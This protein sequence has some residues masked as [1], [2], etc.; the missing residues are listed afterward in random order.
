MTRLVIGSRG[1]ELA[2]TQSTYIA[3]RLRAVS[4]GLEVEVLIIS[5]KG[6]RITDV[7]LS[8]VGGKGLF[9]K[10]LEV[11]LVEGSIDLAVHSLKDLPT[12][13]PGG[14]VVG[15]IPGRE[16]PADA[17]ISAS[18]L[19]L[20]ALPQGATVGTSSTRRQ[21]QLKAV[22]PDLVLVDLRGN[23]PTRLKKL[24]TEGLDAIILAAAGLNRLGLSE[25]ITELLAPE[26]MLSAVG[27]GALGIEIRENDT[28]LKDLLSRIHDADTA[29]AATA[30][31]ALLSGVGGGCQ[32]PLGALA[33]VRLGELHLQACA[34]SPDGTQVVR[35]A[36]SGPADAPEALG[37]AVAKALIEG[38]ASVFI[39][40]VALDALKPK[41]PLAGRTVVVTRSESQGSVLS[42]ELS[43][44]GA[45]VIEFPTISIQEVA[46]DGAI[47]GDGAVDWLIFTSVN[48]VN[49]FASALAREGRSL[50]AFRSAA[51]CAIGPATASALRVHGVPVSLT[52][53]QY[54]AESILEALARLERGVAGKRFLMP[55]GNLARSDL[56]E[57]LRAAGAEVTECVV[58][59]TIMPAVPEATVSAMLAA[60][61]ELVVFTSSSTA[62]NFATILGDARL[63]ALKG[64]VKFASIGPITTETAKALGMTVSIEPEEH[65]IPALVYAIVDGIDTMYP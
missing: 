19:G 63:E 32:V 39:R 13:L 22:R 34:C 14:L 10:E 59:E 44:M 26:V 41:Q 40:Q 49:H 57:A 23:V 28:A 60:A 58:Y 37:Q 11:A 31:R 8:Q 3:E 30:E 15:A 46:P 27:Q 48:G 36:L 5:T 29:A 38:G 20:M 47:P 61:P 43:A 64:S 65:E 35:A 45:K 51:V 53:E 12:E 50:A 7:P 9:T 6:D 42:D 55:R 4:P 25:H 16:N 18:G 1:S 24:E 62:R 17:L 56:P 21:V 52:P 33:V 54:V 2:L